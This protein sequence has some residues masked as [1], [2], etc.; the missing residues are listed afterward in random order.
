MDAT[1]AFEDVGH[2]EDARAMLKDYYVGEL[3]RSSGA[4][5]TKDYS[6]TDKPNG[7]A[8]SSNTDGGNKWLYVIVPLVLVA[9]FVAYKYL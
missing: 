7:Y 3:V 8:N 4:D 5:K 1:E 2:S 6:K 9:A